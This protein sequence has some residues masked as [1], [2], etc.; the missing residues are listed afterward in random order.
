MIYVY[1]YMYIC[2]C[3]D[4]NNNKYV[5][6]YIYIYIYTHTYIY[7]YIYMPPPTRFFAGSAPASERRWEEIFYTPPPPGRD[8]WDCDCTRIETEASIHH[9]LWVVVVVV[10]VV[11]YRFGLPSHG[12]LREISTI[13]THILS[14]SVGT[15]LVKRK[16]WDLE[17]SSILSPLKLPPLQ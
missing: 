3:V 11:V 16:T 14:V 9:P 5:C 7:T 8:F 17:T 4:T 2:I 12:D 15:L 1:T 13:R 10:V 6:M